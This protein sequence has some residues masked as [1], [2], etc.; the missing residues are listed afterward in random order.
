[1]GP[2]NATFNGLKSGYYK[3]VYIHDYYNGYYE[4]GTMTVTI[5]GV[6]YDAYCIDLFTGISSGKVLLVNG[7]LVADGTGSLPSGVDWSKV[8]YILNIYSA[9]GTINGS[10]D[11]AINGAAI[12]CA[13]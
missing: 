3:T 8:N 12:Q 4:A 5:D 11:K 2:R 13:I 6:S 1:L 10:N 9:N 7:A